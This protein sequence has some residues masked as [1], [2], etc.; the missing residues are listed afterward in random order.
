MRFEMKNKWLSLAPLSPRFLLLVI[1]ICLAAMAASLVFEF[2]E[3]KAD[4]I[5]LMSG[6]SE[7]FINTLASATQNAITVAE[8][9]EGILNRHVISNLTLFDMLDAQGSLTDSLLSTWLRFS[10][11]EAIQWYRASG[12]PVRQVS[13]GSSGPMTVPLQ[14]IRARLNGVFPDTV[15]SVIDPSDPFDERLAAL[16]TRRSGGIFAAFI[17]REEIQSLRGLLGIGYFLRRFQS[18]RQI[19]YVV[20]QNSETIVAGSFEGYRISTYSEDSLLAG[21]ELAKVSR[22]RIL[23]YENRSIFETVSPFFLDEVPIGVVRLGLSMEAYE[24]LQRDLYSRLAVFAGVFFVFGLTFIHFLLN[25]RQRSVLLRNLDRLQAYT[26]SILDNLRSGVIGIDRKGL[27]QTANKQALALLDMEYEDVILQSAD[28]LPESFRGAIRQSSESGSGKSTLLQE[29][30]TGPDH[31]KRILSIR[32]NDV[33]DEQGERIRTVLFDDVTDQARLE[34]QVRRNQRLTA[35]KNMAATVAH[36]IKNPLNAIRLNID[37]IRKKFKP[38]KETELYVRNMETVRTEI[39]RI[40]TIVEEYLRYTRPPKMLFKTLDLLKM[41]DELSLIFNT[42]LN[43]KGI[44]FSVDMDRPPEI[45][46]DKDRLKQ[47]FINVI[48]N[49]EES[50]EGKGAIEVKGR[51]RRETYD[52]EFHDTGRGIPSDKLSSVFDFHFTTKSDGSGI[53]LTVVQQIIEA[54][55]GTVEIRSEPGGGTIVVMRFPLDDIPGET[56]LI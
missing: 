26:N 50:I 13:V 19:E 55:R 18:E 14:L 3:Q 53:G 43:E 25:Y 4:Y 44:R 7:L 51:R 20:I 42:Q 46:G 10:G 28:V 36:E 47:A 27:I 1:F 41:M 54:H 34:E 22:S 37:L 40:N 33:V 8:E 30:M 2:R 35:M 29:T 12:E 45:A 17:S 16:V 21:I 24:R 6:Q 39:D 52:I 5:E 9:V 38:E 15:L 23:K 49:A 31:Q 48:K 56:A 11:V 32:C